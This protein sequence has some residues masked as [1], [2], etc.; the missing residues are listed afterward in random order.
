MTDS[1]GSIMVSSVLC[2]RKRITGS[3]TIG[4]LF[5]GRV[6]EERVIDRSVIDRDDLVVY[7]VG[8]GQDRV[9]ALFDTARR[10][11][12][13]YDDRDVPNGQLA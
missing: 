4:F 13:G 12:N 8:L 7:F 1:T 11:V 3:P 2:C 9:K 5:Y 10:I 6:T